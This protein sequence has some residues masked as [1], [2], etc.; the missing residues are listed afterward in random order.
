M[1][2]GTGLFTCGTQWPR[3]KPGATLVVWCAVQVCAGCVCVC[4]CV[5]VHVCVCV[6]VCVCARARAT[7][8]FLVESHPTALHTSR[9]LMFHRMRSGYSYQGSWPYV[10]GTSRVHHD[11][12]PC[13]F[14]PVSRCACVPPVQHLLV[15]E[16]FPG[17]CAGVGL[18]A[19]Q[20]RRQALLVVALILVVLPLAREGTGDSTPVVIRKL[21]LGAGVGLLPLP[22]DY[23]AVSLLAVGAVLTT[24]AGSPRQLRARACACVSARACGGRGCHVEAVWSPE[25]SSHIALPHTRHK[26]GQHTTPPELPL[27]SGGAIEF[28][29]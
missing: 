1:V 19:L 12:A 3:R 15:R 5:C 7:V 10:L 20:L 23:E 14:T 21:R 4:V 9:V 2:H 29:R 25:S 22:L 16:R 11:P 6:C 26:L 8:C 27:A 24:S 17:G 18:L 13:R 28:H